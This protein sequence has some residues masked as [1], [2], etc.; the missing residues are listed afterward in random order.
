M[1]PAMARYVDSMA[2]RYVL[3]PGTSYDRR[4]VL[5]LYWPWPWIHLASLAM[6]NARGQTRIQ[7]RD[8]VSTW[9]FFSEG[10]V[11]NN[12]SAKHN[13]VISWTY[14]VYTREKN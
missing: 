9:L 4:Q 10:I 11:P 1:V 12:L 14:I 2:T 8:G 3:V 6:L 13:L 7:G 5:L